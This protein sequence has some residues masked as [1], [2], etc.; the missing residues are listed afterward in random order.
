MLVAL[1]AVGRVN[2]G[3][4]FVKVGVAVALIEQTIAG[5]I[6][7]GAVEEVLAERVCDFPDRIAGV[8]ASVHS[9]NKRKARAGGSRTKTNADL[10][11]NASDAGGRGLR[12]YVGCRQGRGGECVSCIERAGRKSLPG[13][14]GGVQ[15]HR[16]DDVDKR[17]G[18]ASE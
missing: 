1:G 8:D 13:F 18:A 15:R 4:R 11:G 5:L 6:R 9:D 7:D 17:S 12:G 10:E 2:T 3:F 14:D 16:Y